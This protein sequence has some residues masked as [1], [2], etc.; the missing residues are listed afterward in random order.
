MSRRDCN[1]VILFK[2][3]TKKY[4]EATIESNNQVKS[5]DDGEHEGKGNCDSASDCDGKNDDEGEGLCST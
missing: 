3:S 1:K 4:N 5:E 2:F